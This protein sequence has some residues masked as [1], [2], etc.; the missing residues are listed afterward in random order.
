[1]AAHNK[2]FKAD[3]FGASLTLSLADKMNSDEINIGYIVAW[4]LLGGLFAGYL[5]W[6]QLTES[7]I[8]K[9][10]A[11]LRETVDPHPIKIKEII[12]SRYGTLGI[13]FEYSKGTSELTENFVPRKL[14]SDID[15]LSIELGESAN[16]YVNEI[17][18]GEPAWLEVRDLSLWGYLGEKVG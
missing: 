3:A 13:V 1:M 9:Q 7:R 5:I 14:T 12:L 6:K 8:K 2:S 11:S 16:L 18:K 10:A 17:Q 15:A 4:A